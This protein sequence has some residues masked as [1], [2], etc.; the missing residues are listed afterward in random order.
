[1]GRWQVCLWERARLA[2]IATGN[3]GNTNG[4]E[5]VISL[6]GNNTVTSAADVISTNVTNGQTM[7]SG[8]RWLYFKRRRLGAGASG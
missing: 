4:V 1:M 2:A 3:T 8:R 6:T 5:D 7:G